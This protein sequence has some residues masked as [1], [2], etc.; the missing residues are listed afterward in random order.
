M[1]TFKTPPAIAILDPFTLQPMLEQSSPGATPAPAVWTFARWATFLLSDARARGE[2]ALDTG[3][4]FSTILPA[5]LG[6][7]VIE[8]EDADYARVLPLAK[9]PPSAYQS[10]LLDAQLAPFSAAFCAATD[11][12]K[13]SAL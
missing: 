5:M 1:K 4:L 10:P 9:A 11:A 3:R 2:T 6:E 8:L 12:S 7:K 13:P